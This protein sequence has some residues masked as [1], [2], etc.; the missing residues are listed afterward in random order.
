MFSCCACGSLQSVG[1]SES[2]WLR[3]WHTQQLY[4]R[5]QADLS[6]V[7]HLEQFLQIDIAGTPPH[8]CTAPSRWR[9]TLRI[10]WTWSLGLSRQVA[11][12]Q[13]SWEPRQLCDF[14]TCPGQDLDF[15]VDVKWNSKRRV[16]HICGHRIY[17]TRVWS[18]AM[19]VND[20][21]LFS[22]LNWSD[23]GV[24]RCQL[25]TGWGNYCFWCWCLETCWR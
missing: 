2:W 21:L 4:Q 24:W 1:Q 18:M 25:K 5:V 7:Y 23:R 13:D 11:W 17:R 10:S 9:R 15:K 22:K 6:K 8:A 16:R 20:S 3:F 14:R 12:K 19:L